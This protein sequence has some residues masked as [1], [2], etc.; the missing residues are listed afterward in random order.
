MM[1][2]DQRGIESQRDAGSVNV[3]SPSIK[4]RIRSVASRQVELAGSFEL[5]KHQ[6]VEAMKIAI[7]SDRT[8]EYQ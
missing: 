1:D 8:A 2:R 6:F 5:L 4:H 3:H 7:T